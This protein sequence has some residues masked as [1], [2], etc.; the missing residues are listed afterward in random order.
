M[1]KTWEDRKI[2]INVLIK[3]KLNIMK[4]LKLTAVID[5]RERKIMIVRAQ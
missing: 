3:N 5:Y 1:N 2:K 4:I